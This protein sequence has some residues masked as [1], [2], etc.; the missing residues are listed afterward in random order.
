MRHSSFLSTLLLP[1]LALA[2]AG[3][4][5]PS[6]SGDGLLVSELS[7]YSDEVHALAVDAQGRTLGV[8]WTDDGSTVAT[9]LHRLAEDG[10]PDP[11]FGAGGVTYSL[12][13][14]ELRY[15]HAAGL[16]STGNIIVA[17]LLYDQNLDGN[18]M[19]LRYL[20]DGTPDAS[21]GNGGLLS[22]DY[23]AGFGF[24]SAWA[25]HILPDDR[26]VLTGEDGEN[27]LTVACLTPDGALDPSFGN[28]GV[29][30]AGVSFSSGL[31]LHAY[32][33]GSILAGGYRVDG[34][35]D[36]LLARFASDGALDASFGTNGI[37]TLDI[38]GGDTEF[39]R[40]MGVLS[41]GRIAVCGSRSTSG[42]DDVPTMAL[43]NA[44]GTLDGSFGDNGLLSMLFTAPQWGQ[45]R[46]LIVQ[47]DDKLLV[48]GFRAQPGA[49]AN[50]DFFLIRLLSDGTF[51]P[52]FAGGLVYTDVSGSYDRAFAMALTP[53]GAVVVGGYGT[54]TDHASAYAR[55]LNDIA[56]QVS[57]RSPAAVELHLAPNPAMDHVTVSTTARLASG[58][59]IRLLAMDGTLVHSHRLSAPTQRIE[60]PKHLVAGCYLLEVGTAAGSQRSRLSILH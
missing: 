28:G 1:G 53:T 31:C 55:Y 6:F 30:H 2:Q 38:G 19:V 13:S 37:A 54:G 45:A 42:L 51:D 29:A 50:N 33:D 18:A 3:T 11:S 60:L 44:D 24:Q 8:G 21:F 46:A 10:T 27:G 49:A 35:S 58:G 23:G 26:I 36:W 40:G 22:L 43:F 59:T 12:G 14:G 41:D 57:A 20:P 56:M 47:P 17:G 7:F 32:P 9:F 5:D 15:A 39:M 16:Q 34:G 52:S 48:A 4:L 25:M